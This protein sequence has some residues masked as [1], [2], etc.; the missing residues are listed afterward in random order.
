MQAVKTSR[1]VYHPPTAEQ[2][3]AFDVIEKKRQW[4]IGWAKFACVVTG[5]IV[6]LF[7][8]DVVASNMAASGFMD[9]FAHGERDE[10]MEYVNHD[11]E[12]FRLNR[13]AEKRIHVLQRSSPESVG[14]DAI[15]VHLMNSLCQVYGGRHVQAR[16]YVVHGKFRSEDAGERDA[17]MSI[18]VSTWGH[19]VV[20]VAIDDPKL[21]PDLTGV[22]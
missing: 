21:E 22:D 3:A 14:E 19:L 18:W 13:Y 7:V 2:S 1:P 10:M 5:G 12:S 8:W 4:I 6:A 15:A 17:T 11:N 9:G 16:K 20:K